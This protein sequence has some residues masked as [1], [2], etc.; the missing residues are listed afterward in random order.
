[1]LSQVIEIDGRGLR[2]DPGDGEIAVQSYYVAADVGAA[3]QPWRRRL[4]AFDARRLRPDDLP[5][6]VLRASYRTSPA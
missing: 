1:M 6:Q 4:L 3:V 5:E 2:A